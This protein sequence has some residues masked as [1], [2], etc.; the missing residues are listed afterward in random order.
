MPDVA[1]RSGVG[2]ATAVYRPANRR[3]PQDA[4]HPAHDCPTDPTRAGPYYDRG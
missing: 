3:A 4:Q 1:R 2:R